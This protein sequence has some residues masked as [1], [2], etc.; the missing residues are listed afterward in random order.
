MARDGYT[1]ETLV[2]NTGEALKANINTVEGQEEFLRSSLPVPQETPEDLRA[3]FDKMFPGQ[4]LII[5][6]PATIEMR[7]QNH[8]NTFNTYVRLAAEYGV[9]RRNPGHPRYLGTLYKFETDQGAI[10]Y[11]N[12]L[13]EAFDKND[14]KEVG[15]LY[16]EHILNLPSVDPGTI[17]NL[18]PEEAPGMLR[19][20]YPLYVAVAE[21]VRFLKDKDE[22]SVSIKAG[23]SEESLAR[24]KELS[25]LDSL[26][27]SLKTRCDEMFTPYHVYLD[28][29][30]I[31]YTQ[32]NYMA[33][34]SPPQGLSWDLTQHLE[35]MGSNILFVANGFG[36]DTKRLLEDAGVDAE[37]AVAWDFCGNSYRVS[38]K[39]GYDCGEVYRRGE[40]VFCTVGNQLKAFK[41]DGETIV[42]VQPEKALENCFKTTLTTVIKETD[43]LMNGSVAAPIW[44][45]TGSSQYRGMQKAYAAYQKLVG[46]EPTAEKLKDPKAKNA[47]DA[48]E[49]AA[50]AYFELKGVNLNDF[51][52]YNTFTWRSP[53][54]E[55]MS[56]R[57][58]ARMMS[59]YQVL[60]TY[61]LTAGA[62][63]TH[64]DLSKYPAYKEPLPVQR[65]HGELVREGNAKILQ[66]GFLN[67]RVKPAGNSSVNVGETL[68]QEIKIALIDPTNGLLNKKFFTT[69]DRQAAEDVL[70]KAV[71]LSM[72]SS[73]RK[74]ATPSAIEVSYE[75]NAAGTM[76]QIK[77]SEAFQNEKGKFISPDGLRNFLANNR[78]AEVN[79]SLSRS[80][81]KQQAA[82]NAEVQPQPRKNMELNANAPQQS[83]QPVQPVSVP[84]FGG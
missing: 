61:N 69:Q 43:D 79:K 26:F 17:A 15:R 50:K 3:V 78:Q 2:I 44:M 48:L 6:D 24:L 5:S 37:N 21:S 33:L 56:E 28:T 22:P 47:L 38:D 71:I 4:N 52:D 57:E 76:D 59:A 45:F 35:K 32:A 8:L 55:N 34:S 41:A 72:I 77:K 29:S 51:P 74:A 60:N 64:E 23:M 25:K 70:A 14:F 13:R 1:F 66:S 7:R 81:V 12:H 63:K 68:R 39:R 18:S 75:K 84:G 46:G 9:V 73:G 65:P 16:A 58:L 42:E 54:A 11:N 31:A 80:A 49:S 62:V 83:Q 36:D 30:K 20:L 67:E 53:L 82:A 19:E 27:T 10:D 40:P